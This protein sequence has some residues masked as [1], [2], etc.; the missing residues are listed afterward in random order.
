MLTEVKLIGNDQI[1]NG[2]PVRGPR[3]TGSPNHKTNSY[4][5]SRY[6]IFQTFFE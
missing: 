4:I 1:K 2:Y 5:D 3:L 6:L